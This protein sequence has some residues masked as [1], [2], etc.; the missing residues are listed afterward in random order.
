[1]LGIDVDIV[2]YE[3]G[4]YKDYQSEIDAITTQQLNKHFY[5]LGSLQ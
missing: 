5:K 3:L 2:E 1:M 4:A